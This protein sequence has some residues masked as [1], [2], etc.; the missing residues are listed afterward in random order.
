MSFTF[1][2]LAWFQYIRNIISKFHSNILGKPLNSWLAFSTS[3]RRGLLVPSDSFSKLSAGFSLS[4]DPLQTLALLGMP[5]T[6]EGWWEIAFLCPN[7]G[8]RL[9]SDINF[10][11]FGVPFIMGMIFSPKYPPSQKIEGLRGSSWVVFFMSWVFCTCPE[12][13]EAEVF[14]AHV[15][16]SMSS[17]GSFWIFGGILKSEGEIFIFPCRG[18][19]SP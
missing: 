17:K 4:S 13:L 10:R 19:G 2:L 11:V 1:S 16:T 8:V 14:T 15:Q 7:E 12:T 5:R 9:E 18:G 6:L 3:E